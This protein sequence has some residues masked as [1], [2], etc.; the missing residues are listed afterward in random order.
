MESS[1]D[2]ESDDWSISDA[3]DDSTHSHIGFFRSLGLTTMEELNNLTT[4]F[5][6]DKISSMVACSI[7]CNLLM[8]L[9]VEWL[10]VV[11]SVLSVGQSREDVNVFRTILR[12][13]GVDD[14]GL[15]ISP[16]SSKSEPVNKRGTHSNWI[17]LLSSICSHSKKT[18]A[19]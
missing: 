6:S 11:F 9:G 14:T 4:L 16:N 19:G 15:L 18:K 3:T 7:H 1:A 13:E 5:E 12:M 2:M 17:S 8:K 10:K